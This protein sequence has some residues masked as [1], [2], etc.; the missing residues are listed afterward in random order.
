MFE[1]NKLIFR[2]F[3]KGKPDRVSRAAVVQPLPLADL[4]LFPSGTRSGPCM[5]SGSCGL[6]ALRPRG[7]LLCPTSS[8]QQSRPPRSR[9]SRGRICATSTVSQSSTSLWCWPGVH[10]TAAF[11]RNARPWFCRHGLRLLS[12]KLCYNVLLGNSWSPPLCVATFA[13]F[14]DLYWFTTWRQLFFYPVD[15]PGIDLSW[16]IA[17]GVVFTAARLCHFGYDVSLTCFCGERVETLDHLFFYFPLAQSGISWFQ[18]SLFR[19]SPLSPVLV[20]RHLSV[21]GL[22][23]QFCTG[24]SSH[25]VVVGTFTASGAPVAFSQRWSMAGWFS[26]FRSKP[27]FRLAP[28]SLLLVTLGLLFLRRPGSPGGLPGLAGLLLSFLFFFG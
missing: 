4:V 3:W 12:C 23:Y 10:L 21:W 5:P 1:L 18:S 6:L 28:W 24:A 25:H 26:K 27:S 7:H 15:R 11:R 19:C 22:T 16:K 8:G 14:G 2:F 13:H 9:S 20:C 17:H